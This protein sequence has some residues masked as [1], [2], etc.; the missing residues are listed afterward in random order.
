METSQVARSV[1]RVITVT[2]TTLAC[3][4]TACSQA[5]SYPSKPIRIVVPYSGGSSDVS[6]RVLAP[7]LSES[8][9]QPVLVENRAG[10]NGLLGTEYVARANPDGHTLL[11]VLT[12]HA[13]SGSLLKLPYD[14]IKDFAPVAAMSVAELG[15]AVH[16][17]VPANTLQEFIAH[18]KSLPQPL[19][20]STT[21]IGGNQH[22]A[23]ELFTLITGAKMLAVPYKGGGDALA[24]VLG[25]QVQMYFGSMASLSPVFKAGKLRGLAVTGPARD[26]DFPNIP[27][28]TEG[29]VPGLDIRLWYGFLAP[30]ATPRD[31]VN[32]LSGL[33]VGYVA[34]PD[35]KATLAKQGMD[36]MPLDSAQFAKF[37][38]SE[39]ASYASIV[40]RA[41]IKIDP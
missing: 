40:K 19:T 22:L 11:S 1:H 3:A 16:N 41:N 9:K 21:Q 15:M 13:I 12:T 23:G 36:P 27:T 31:V 20:Y 7:K 29:G 38:R 24:A 10:A 33:I 28:F 4:F 2:L 34:Q 30:A 8:L 25:G 39:Q 37:L 32:R 5:Q 6:A 14:P 17:G 35:F 18:A 26:P